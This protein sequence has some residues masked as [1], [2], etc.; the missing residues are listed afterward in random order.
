MVEK[1]VFELRSG[2]KCQLKEIFKGQIQDMILEMI[3][4]GSTM[5]TKGANRWNEELK[6]SEKVGKEEGRDE[7]DDGEESKS[8][9]RSQSS[10]FFFFR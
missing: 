5:I 1:I 10:F 6:K 7:H 4:L 8:E 3:M 9:F 2:D